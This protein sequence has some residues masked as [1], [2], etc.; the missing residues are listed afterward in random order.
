MGCQESSPMA[1]AAPAALPEGE[2]AKTLLVSRF[3]MAANSDAKTLLK[4]RSAAGAKLEPAMPS[5]RVGIC[6]DAMSEKIS[7]L[8]Q[9]VRTDAGLLEI[10]CEPYIPL[11]VDAASPRFLLVTQCYT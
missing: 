10:W 6:W 2:P 11:E 5:E 3:A 8:K 1:A 4:S 9:M 7:A